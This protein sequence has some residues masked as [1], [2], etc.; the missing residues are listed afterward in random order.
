MP[1]AALLCS[2]AFAC[3][4]YEQL[5]SELLPAEELTGQSQERLKEQ[6]R[7]LIMNKNAQQGGGPGNGVPPAVGVQ[8]INNLSPGAALRDMFS[9][10]P[11]TGVQDWNLDGAVQDI[12]LTGVIGAELANSTLWPQWKPGSEFKAIRD[13]SGAPK[14]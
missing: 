7:R 8:L 3:S 10:S 12:A 11:S 5:Y 1:C 6:V 2:L 14:E 4:H 13:R 9:F